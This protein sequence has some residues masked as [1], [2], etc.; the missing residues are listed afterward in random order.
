MSRRTVNEQL[1]IKRQLKSG[2]RQLE[3]PMKCARNAALIVEQVLLS[4]PTFHRTRAFQFHSAEHHHRGV[5]HIHVRKRRRD[6]KRRTDLAHRVGALLPMPC[7]LGIGGHT[8]GSWQG[9]P[10][11]TSAHTMRRPWVVHYKPHAIPPKRQNQGY[12]DTLWLPTW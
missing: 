2:V 1:V 5:G 6:D 10:R 12:R 8:G 3:T 7:C 4:V 11:Y 9:H